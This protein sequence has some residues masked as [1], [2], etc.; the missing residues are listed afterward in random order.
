MGAMYHSEAVVVS[1]SASPGVQCH[2]PPPE[3]A[4]S[5]GKQAQR[6]VRDGCTGDVPHACHPPHVHMPCVLIT[7]SSP[8]HLSHRASA[9]PSSNPPPL[10]SWFEPEESSTAG[11]EA[12]VQNGSVPSTRKCTPCGRP[13]PDP[14]LSLTLPLSAPIPL[15][16]SSVSSAL[17]CCMAHHRAAWGDALIMR[18]DP[19]CEHARAC[20]ENGGG[21]P[22]AHRIA[23][24]ATLGRITTRRVLNPCGAHLL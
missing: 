10:V 14:A 16:E 17:I 21:R 19:R 5:I 3:P 11:F 23:H 12:P 9:V 15:D 24:L 2:A 6:R 1:P 7:I 22:R 13:R 4:S 18:E 8:V 20:I